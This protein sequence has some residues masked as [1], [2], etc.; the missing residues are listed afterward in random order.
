MCAVLFLGLKTS[1]QK[2]GIFFMGI[3]NRTLIHVCCFKNGRNL[4]I[5]SS[6]KATLL[7]S[8]KKMCILAPFDGTHGCDFPY[9][10]VISYILHFIFIYFRLEKLLINN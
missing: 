2:F 3:R 8:Q 9:F 1:T 5:P 6:K 10:C 7:W 4:R